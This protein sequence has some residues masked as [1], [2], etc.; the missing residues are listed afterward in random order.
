MKLIPKFT[1]LLT[2]A[3]GLAVASTK[4]DTFDYS[5]LFG[6]GLF[7]SGS[8]D[9][10]ANGNFVEN[11]SNVSVLFNGVAIP[12]SGVVTGSYDGSSFV[13]GPAVV[14][15]DA[16]SNNFLFRS[17]DLDV[18]FYLVNAAVYLSDTAT[19][20]AFTD[21][22]FLVSSEDTN[23]RGGWS[24]KASTVPDGSTTLIPLGLTMIGLAWLRFAVTAIPAPKRVRVI[25]QISRR[26]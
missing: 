6:D 4:A 7:V 24:L 9:G 26:S 5:Y 18:G 25:S 3:L 2:A 21:D 23:V 19:A 12:G 13:D 10:T 17:S 20:Y 22:L 1:L 15:F 8:L 14:S 16:L 11:V